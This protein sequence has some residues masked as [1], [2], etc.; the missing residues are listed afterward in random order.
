[1]T[2][3]HIDVERDVDTTAATDAT[4]SGAAAA[5]A[6]NP[7]P[8]P[9]RRDSSGAFARFASVVNDESLAAL[10]PRQQAALI[11]HAAWQLTWPVIADQSLMTLV[12]VVNMAMLGRLGASAIAASGLSF[13]PFMLVSNTFMGLS[14]GTT[15]LV[16]RFI[17]AGDEKRASA[18]LQQSMLL[19]I[20]LGVA[21]TLVGIFFAA[22]IVRVMRPQPDV[23]ALGVK[24]VRAM[25]P[26][27]AFMIIL[28]MAGAAL[29]GAGDTRTPM[30]VNI[31]V[32]LTNVFV[33]WTLIFGH[34]GLPALGIIGAGT[35]TSLARATGGLLIVY[36]L[37]SNQLILRLNWRRLLHIDGSILKRLWNVGMPSGLERLINST[38][39]LL[40]V[41]QVSGLGTIAYATHALAMNVESLSFMPGQGFSTAASTLVGLNLGARRP[42][43]AEKSAIITAQLGATIMGL[44]GVLF[45]LVPS[46][47]LHIYTGDA[48]I[49]ALGVVALRIV[50]LEQVPEAVGS[51]LSGALRGAGDTRAVLAV[52]MAG[53]WVVRL[54]LSP[55]LI[56]TAGMG[57]PGAWIAMLA[58]WTFR[59]T[60]LAI[61]FK[62]GRW[63]KVKL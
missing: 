18:T 28:T 53:V 56:Q 2:R 1:M 26:G 8:S 33:S 60:V 35:A 62:S 9:R 57:A 22:P 10:S 27:L 37:C 6:P 15:A 21:V 24:Y 51:V 20:V 12:Q 48:A 61:V 11:R 3:L 17:G 36:L 23:L 7:I 45:F 38:G 50:A 40:Y 5:P 43:I 55:L 59:A 41:R 42:A 14:V 30:A 47:F 46:L 25:S 49:I 34:F 58:D 31:I 19:G 4:S 29:R 44:A 39:Q 63:K 13:Q 16:A 54:G 52:T 32:N